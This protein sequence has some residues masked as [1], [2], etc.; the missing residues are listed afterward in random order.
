MLESHLQSLIVYFSAH[1]NVALG[2][3]FAASMLEALA[4][5]GTVIPGSSIVFIGGILIG[6]GALDPWRTAAAAVCGAILGDGISYWLGHHYRQRLPQLWPMRRYPQLLA[7]GQAYFERNGGKSVFLGRFLGPLRA[8]VPVA[9]GMSSMPAARFY[10]VNVLSAIAWAAAHLLPGWLFGASLQLAGAVSERLA[11]MLVV[12]V[13]ALWAISK[14]VR[15]AFARTWP[16][17][18]SLRDRSVE[19]ARR[20]SG[21][22]AQVA[23]SLLDPARPESRGLLVAAVVLIGGTWLF[24]GVL[25]DVLANDPLVR[26]DQSVYESLQNVRTAWADRL[27]VFVTELGGTPGT[28]PVIAATSAWL[29]FKRRWRTLAYWLAAGVDFDIPARRGAPL[30]LAWQPP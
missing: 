15:L 19:R 23:L 13:L 29:A 14:L 21:P 6:L 7:R 26:F 25:E 1:P 22:I 8:V 11:L 5:V 12:V 24:L 3:V 20:G 18:T 16:W 10:V 30:M 4:V 27:M 28:L 9:A 2:A 17:I